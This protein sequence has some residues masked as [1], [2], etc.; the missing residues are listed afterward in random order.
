MGKL[1][2]LVVIGVGIVFASLFLWHRFENWK[3]FR[4]LSGA[5][6]YEVLSL[7]P[8]FVSLSP[9][10][11]SVQSFHGRAILGELKAPDN[12]VRQKLSEALRS[13]VNASDG[14]MKACFNPRHGIR[15][16]HSG[17][18][19]DYVVCF[20]CLQIEVWRNDKM[21]AHMLTNSSPEPLFDA[22]LRE[23][24]VPLAPKTP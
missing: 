18:V 10:P 9:R 19:T 16:T 8:Y 17:V 5:D 12:S 4:A 2:V 14:R 7:D 21:V 15:V 24:G 6:Q 3:A 22:I 1:F 23:A 20:E 13:G 11:E